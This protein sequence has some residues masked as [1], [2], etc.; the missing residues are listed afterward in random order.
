LKR[1]LAASLVVTSVVGACV[2]AEKYNVILARYLINTRVF[3]K[4]YMQLQSVQEHKALNATTDY[5]F[6]NKN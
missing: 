3:F 1:R 2:S 6:F 5:P 4:F